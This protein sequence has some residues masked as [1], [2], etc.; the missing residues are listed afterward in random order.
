VMSSYSAMVSYPNFLAADEPG[1]VRAAYS[2][3]VFERLT[4]VK[5]RFDPENVF[6]I[7]NNILPSVVGASR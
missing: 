4:T 2:P 7:N 3:A 1:D 6:R 5:D